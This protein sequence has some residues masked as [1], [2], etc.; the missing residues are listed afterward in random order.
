MTTVGQAS[1]VQLLHNY[2]VN[3]CSPNTV[4]YE[5]IN[6][7][8]RKIIESLEIDVLV[9]SKDKTDTKTLNVVNI[10]ARLLKYIISERLKLSR[11]S[12]RLQKEE[13]PIPNH[14][15]YIQKRSEYNGRIQKNTTK[16]FKNETLSKPSKRLSKNNL[17]VLENWFD[18]NFNDPY[19][20][21]ISLRLLITTTNLSKSQIQNWVSNRRRKER[22][23]KISPEIMELLT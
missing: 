2:I 18:E 11:R 9:N 16:N 12:A 15:F 23:V 10:C 19:L 3:L 14:Q 22:R 5:I 13:Q 1:T 8:I 21:N 4:N 6:K 20:N 17:K 7:D